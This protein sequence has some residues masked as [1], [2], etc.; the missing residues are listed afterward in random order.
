MRKF[1][2]AP[3]RHMARGAFLLAKPGR[4]LPPARV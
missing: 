3:Q 1:E 2:K 4:G